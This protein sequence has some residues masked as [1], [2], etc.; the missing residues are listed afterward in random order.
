MPN[1]S[2][3]HWKVAALKNAEVITDAWEVAK[4]YAGRAAEWV[5]FLCMITNI[6]AMLPG[7]DAPAG[8]TNLVLGVQVVML[9]IGGMSLS[10]MAA[11]IRERGEKAAARKASLTSTFLIG[12]MILTLLLVSIGVL[13]PALKSYTDMAEKGLILV[14][15]VMTVV[16]SHV[17]HSLRASGTPLPVLSTPQAAV[18]STVP[19]TTEL[20]ALIRNM[21]VPVLEQYRTEISSDVAAKVE[22][23]TPAIDYSQLAAALQGCGAFENGQ[24]PQSLKQPERRKGQ[25]L[26]QLPAP[27]SIEGGKQ[28]RQARLDAAYCELLQEGVKPTGQTLSARARCNRAV[29][30]AWLKHYGGKD[31]K[32]ASETEHTDVLENQG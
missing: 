13:F 26:Q 17:M 25:R 11:S 15:V 28:D 7:M 18:P 29:A 27:V 23:A 8:I 24:Q 12:L 9:D 32:E 6:I 3:P 30:L 21:L 22:P 10:S 5:L 2:A 20:E 16:Y 1:A 19:N 14:R 31:E 4:A